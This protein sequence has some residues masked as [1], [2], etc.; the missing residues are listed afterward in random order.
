MNRSRSRVD[1]VAWGLGL[2]LPALLLLG[3]FSTLP[4]VIITGEWP[5]GVRPVEVAAFQRWFDRRGT[6]ADTAARAERFQLDGPLLPADSKWHPF[7]FTAK[8]FADSVRV[9]RMRAVAGGLVIKFNKVELFRGQHEIV[10]MPAAI[11]SL[12]AKYEEIMA[13]ELGLIAP[14]ISFVELEAPGAEGLYMKEER[15]DAG[16]LEKH[17]LADGA[18]F[19]QGFAEGRPDHAFASFDQ[20]TL[21]PPIVAAK[22]LR[23][24]QG[25]DDP[26]RMIDR[27]AAAALLLMVGIAGRSDL[28]LH[29]GLYAYRWTTGRVL[30]LYRSRRDAAVDVEQGTLATSIFHVLLRDPSFVALMKAKRDQLNE[31]AWRLKERFAAMDQAWLPVLARGNA[32]ESARAQTDRIERDLL[33]RLAALDPQQ[34][35]PATPPFTVPPQFADISDE[36]LVDPQP[37]GVVAAA[38]DGE[39]IG[40]SLVLR[41]G[42]HVILRDLVLPVGVALVIEK[43]ARLELAPGVSVLVQGPLIVRGTAVNPVF[44]RPLSEDSPFGS[45][46]VSVD[47]R[48][49][50]ACDLR[51]LR[52]SGGS[53]AHINGFY[54]SGMLSIHGA[55]E[56]VMEDCEVGADHGEDAVNIKRGRVSIRGC[57]FEDGHADLVD[58][59]YVNGEVLDC[60]FRNGR[61]DSNG[62]GLDVSG[63]QVLVRGCSFVKLLDKGISVGE[64]S[65]VLVTACTFTGDRL[66][67]AVKDL[68]IAHVDACEF[69]ENSTV[70]GVYRKKPI[71]GGARLLLYSNTFTGNTRDREVDAFSAILQKDVLDPKVKLDFGL[72]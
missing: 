71:H 44:I 47:D 67:L 57:V 23:A 12:Q 35:L 54:H 43:S 30:P 66:A 55:G 42:K 33:T 36:V 24:L 29:E 7:L 49:K 15:I 37:L 16:F 21:A 2:G 64:V 48:S 68:S 61:E 50:T 56:V 14:E 51:G 6:D 18:L 1:L 34:L 10:L 17:R 11:G 46:A 25:S 20:D 69:I 38:T 22:Q 45:I 41:R 65:R 70:F 9:R 8:G 59:D 58:L 32:L 3:V 63:S 31:E 26:A 13:T 28:L 60:V 62:D 4:Y 53:E 52:I 27:D 72:R 19:T 5:V 39:A 40:D